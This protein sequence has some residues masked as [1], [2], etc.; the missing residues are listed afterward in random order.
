MSSSTFAHWTISKRREFPT[1]LLYFIVY[2]LFL[3]FVSSRKNTQRD[4]FKFLIF[5][6]FDFLPFLAP[7]R[8]FGFNKKKKGLSE[9]R[10]FFLRKKGCF[11]GG[12]KGFDLLLFVLL[13]CRVVLVVCLQKKKM[14]EEF[15]FFSKEAKQES[16]QPKASFTIPP[17]Y[18]ND[19]NTVSPFE[20]FV[21]GVCDLDHVT[22]ELSTAKGSDVRW[23]INTGGRSLNVS[24][25][26]TNME[27]SPDTSPTHSRIVGHCP[28]DLERAFQTDAMTTQV[29]VP[30]SDML[31]A[32]HVTIATTIPFD[33][34]KKDL[35][36]QAPAP[37]SAF[38]QT[39]ETVAH[40]M[41]PSPWM[42]QPTQPPMYTFMPPLC[43]P[44]P[45][46][47][48]QHMFNAPHAMNVPMAP[49]P[50]A[51]YPM[52]QGGAPQVMMISPNTVSYVMQPTNQGTYILVPVQTMP[53]PHQGFV[54]HLR[55]VEVPL[56]PAPRDV[57]PSAVEKVREQLL[58]AEVVK[59]IADSNRG[60]TCGF[61]HMQSCLR[62]KSLDVVRD[63]LLRYDNS[64]HRWV[65][66]CPS[67]SI[68]QYTAFDI[69]RLELT[70]WTEEHELRICVASSTNY[71]A[72]DKR[73]A[74][75][76]NSCIKRLVWT[77]CCPEG[78][79]TW[80]SF[81]TSSARKYRT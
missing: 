62:E 23:S 47:V 8:L 24:D 80:L 13:S 54:P 33:A 15:V 79:W 29:K 49:F 61:I 10:C 63:G 75:T 46:Q 9:K 7:K 2:L 64:W 51:T 65:E 44:N 58:L 67:L 59:H 57:R 38:Q 14:H 41:K 36:N 27:G 26:S 69:T 72:V 11:F 5:C 66:A 19:H 52:Q 22:F 56:R 35:V 1:K 50:M 81:V 20:I 39:D 60:G 43:A 21:P 53:M 32:P 3:V 78:P 40:H 77:W 71:E 17:K 68:V 55:P 37:P 12:E 6:R 70:G 45:Y 18:V 28:T 31:M 30:T 73:M 34:P 74:H 4:L 25:R 48:P 42:L 76:H 16:V